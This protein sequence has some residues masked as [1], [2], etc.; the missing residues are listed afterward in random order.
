M[1]PS[2]PILE[3]WALVEP[4]WEIC[5][6]TGYG[7]ALDISVRKIYGIDGIRRDTIEM[8]NEA[9]MKSLAPGHF[10]HVLK[11]ICGI[12][13][14]L[15]DGFLGRFECDKELF[16][17]VWRPEHYI[18]PWND[19]GDIIRWLEEEYGIKVRTFD[20]WL[21]AFDKELHIALSNGVV[22][23]KCGLAYTRSLYFEKVDYKT[24]YS[25]FNKALEEWKKDGFLFCLL[26]CRIS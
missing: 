24:A 19:K 2:L 10:R 21:G 9:F 5:R 3:R 17:R 11:E 1:D 25:V 16:R 8:L 22:A 23:L 13:T 12:H 20:D 6:Y 7:R 18:I 4:Y 26:K 15:L 14:S